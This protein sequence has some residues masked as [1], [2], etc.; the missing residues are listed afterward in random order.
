M[1]LWISVTRNICWLLFVSIYLVGN[2]YSFTYFINNFFCMDWST[3]VCS[4]F[5]HPKLP[6]QRRYY[7]DEKLKQRERR[8]LP[9]QLYQCRELGQLYAQHYQDE[10]IK[11]AQ[12]VNTLLWPS[13]FLP[14]SWAS[15]KLLFMHSVQ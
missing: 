13:L 5:Q 6:K 10:H 1:C 7:G 14:K 15:I 3:F 9:V 11:D 4:F 2:Y 8:Q 12:K